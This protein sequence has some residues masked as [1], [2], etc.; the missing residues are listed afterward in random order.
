MNH[1]FDILQMERSE[2]ETLR[3]RKRHSRADEIYINELHET[4]VILNQKN[5]TFYDNIKH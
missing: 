5:A 4:A 2:K 3:Q 1:L